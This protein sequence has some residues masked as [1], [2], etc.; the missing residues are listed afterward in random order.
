MNMHS[1]EYHPI[2]PGLS[3]MPMNLGVTNGAPKDHIG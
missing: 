1:M 2:T 3:G